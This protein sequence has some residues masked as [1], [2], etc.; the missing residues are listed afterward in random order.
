MLLLVQ[1]KKKKEKEEQERMEAM[2]LA[3]KE[4]VEREDE[5][6][7]IVPLFLVIMFSFY[8]Y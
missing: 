3:Y 1:D 8:Y 2:Y 5:V 7:S 4:N 6:Q